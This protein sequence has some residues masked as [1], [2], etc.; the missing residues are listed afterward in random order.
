MVAL[1]ILVPSVSVRIAAV[2]QKRLL[3]GVFFVEQLLTV[4][5]TPPPSPRERGWRQKPPGLLI[6]ATSYTKTV[7]NV[8]VIAHLGNESHEKLQKRVSH[9]PSVAGRW[10][11][12]QGG[13]RGTRIRAQLCLRNGQRRF[14]RPEVSPPLKGLPAATRESG[15]AHG[16]KGL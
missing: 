1:G 9:C 7:K 8:L 14:S 6:R 13:G 11:R 15:Q 10:R 5:L 16:L 2:Q 12:P 4:T 3:D